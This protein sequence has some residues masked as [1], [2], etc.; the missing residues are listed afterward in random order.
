[1]L[2]NGQTGWIT[3]LFS[4]ILVVLM[5][6]SCTQ[7]EVLISP[8]INMETT[9]PDNEVAATYKD[10]KVTKV[11]LQKFIDALTFINP[12]Q[13]QNKDIPA[14]REFILKQ[15]VMSK[16]LTAHA[17]EQSKSAAEIKV[18]QQ[19]DPINQM[20]LKNREEFE[21]N[22]IA[23]NLEFAD[24]EQYF[25]LTLTTIEDI[26]NK[27][28]DQQVT[29]D[30]DEKVKADPNAFAVVTLSH[31]LIA[32]KDPSDPAQ[33]KDLRTKEE[34][35]RRAQEV[36]DKLKNGGDFVAL[37]K[38]YSDD[39]VSKDYGG[40]YE[41]VEVN[42]FVADFK[43]AALE[44]PLNTISEP[45]AGVSGYHIMKVES[46]SVRTFD[47]VKSSIRGKLANDLIVEFMT[48]EFSS[49]NYKSNLPTPVPTVIPSILP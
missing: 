11:E 20:D 23:A 32:Q 18:K 43:K 47:E 40:K 28:T 44:L 13:A 16:I 19:I 4:T 14:F 35:L 12:S 34:A 33:E 5:L 49:Y 22:L 30:F 2:K 1:M 15:L 31:M 17:S 25:R 26:S 38:E 45:I 27:V 8:N 41:K 37:T 6:S 21:K 10:G 24:I 3:S 42:E 46:R 39:S 36:K 9:T 7:K 48:K 29:D